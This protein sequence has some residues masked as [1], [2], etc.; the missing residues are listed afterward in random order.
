MS[1]T[2]AMDDGGHGGWSSFAGSRSQ[3]RQ[4]RDARRDRGDAPSSERTHPARG[5]RGVSEGEQVGKSS[6]REGEGRA[7]AMQILLCLRCQVRG[8]LALAPHHPLFCRASP[9]LS[10]FF[11]TESPNRLSSHFS[12]FRDPI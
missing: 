2:V 1:V 10:I 4:A 8:D 6:R 11:L 9:H 3:I 12:S 7:S 5:E